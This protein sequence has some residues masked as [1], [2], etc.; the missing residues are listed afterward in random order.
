[1]D[2]IPGNFASLCVTQ[3]L[4]GRDNLISSHFQAYNC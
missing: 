1:M 2:E 4:E 3:S